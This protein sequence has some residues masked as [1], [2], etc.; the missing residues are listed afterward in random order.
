MAYLIGI[1]LALG[2]AMFARLARFDRDR[3][4]YPTILVITA[5]YYALFAVMAGSMSTLAYET[6]ALVAF[7]VMA[8]IGFHTTLW[9]VVGGLAAHGLFDF[10]R[11]A[12][13]TNS[14]VPSWWP[15]FCLS[16]DFM[17]AGW[18]AWLLLRMEARL[19]LRP[20]KDRDG[21]ATHS[22][23]S[24]RI[25]DACPEEHLPLRERVERFA[26]VVDGAD[27]FSL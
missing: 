6:V 9:F 27:L 26:T 2:I 25:S 17:A 12:L 8:V 21:H 7:A 19:T 10:F 3:S 5:S 11:S 13:I 15:M 20:G 1:S 24:A 16:F 23:P 22:G 4:F 18:L 14:G